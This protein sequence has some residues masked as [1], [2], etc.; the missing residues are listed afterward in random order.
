MNIKYILSTF[1]FLTSI[2]GFSQVPVP[3]GEQ[4]EA[5]LLKGGIAHLGNGKVIKNSLIAFDEGR[6][7]V[8]ADATTAKIDIVGYKE[9]DISGQHVYPGF[10]LP[11]SQVGLQE[12]S[13]VRAMRDNDEVGDLNPNVRS[14]VAFNT[15]SELLSTYRFNGILMAESTPSGGR[16]SGTSSVMN[17]DGWNW[18]DAVHTADIGIHLNWPRKEKREFDY[19]T[20]TFKTEPNKEYDNEVAELKELLDAATSYRGLP[21]K[22]RNLKLE[23]LLGLYDGSKTLFIHTNNPKEIVDGVN[24]A[25]E[26]G[27]K[28]VAIV[29]GTGALLVKTFL[30]E[31]VIAVVIPPVHSLPSRADMDVDLPYRLPALLTDAGVNVSLSHS[32]MLANA[33]NLAFYAGTA[34]AY[35]MDK[36]EALKTITLNPATVLGIDD[37]VGTLEE[38][39]DATLFVSEGDALDIRTNKLSHAY[40]QGKTIVL[41]N[42]QQ[43]L[44][45]R[46]SKKYG[47]ID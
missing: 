38:G 14:L 43:E 27:V 9:I 18:Q 17:M 34:V 24:F 4:E 45:K 37:K 12:V 39:K 31:N 33:R 20:Y 5:I 36:E 47:H 44:Y 23:A 21:T 11:N 30:K 8:V 35:G 42:K 46:Y 22:E 1:L 2:T 28:K 40:I 26:N 29:A 19:A 25:K 10:I 13:S 32:G 6:I 3:A 16:I 15:D 41:D 7:T